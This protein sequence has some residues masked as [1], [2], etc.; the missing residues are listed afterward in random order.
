MGEKDIVQVL[1][2]NPSRKE[3]IAHWNPKT[4]LFGKSTVSRSQNKICTFRRG[5]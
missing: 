5:H 4:K 1:G 2:T 3:I